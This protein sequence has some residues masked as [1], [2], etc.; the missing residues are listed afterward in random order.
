LRADSVGLA[1]TVIHELTHNTFYAPGQAVFN[2]SFANFVGMRG[3]AW[4]FRSRGDT[5][6]A[7]RSDAE[8]ADERTMGRFWDQLYGS[9]DSAFRANPASRAA[10]LAA[11]EAILARAESALSDSVLPALRIARPHG[12]VRVHLNN[13]VLLA[14]RIY[15][16]RLDLFDAIYAREDYDL[17]RTVRRIIALAKTRPDDP[18]GALQQEGGES[19]AY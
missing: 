6:D 18:Y 15:R 17:R 12:R 4:F 13:A 3:A 19:L 10:R 14:N 16:T 5:E 1:S 11:R 2:E 8:W 9:L 7:A